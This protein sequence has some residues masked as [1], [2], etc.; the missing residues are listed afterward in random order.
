MS[1]PY[2]FVMPLSFKQR[3]KILQNINTLDLTPLKLHA[4]EVDNENI[5]TVIYPKF[6]NELVKK[7]ILPML[8]FTDFEIKLEKFGSAVWMN[9]N[10]KNKIHDIIKIMQSKFWDEFQDA[11]ARVIKFIFQIYE[12]KLISFNELNR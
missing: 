7:F 5:V 2:I 4:E 8:K 12:Q 1:A 6:K 11:E 9:M 10:G 3:K